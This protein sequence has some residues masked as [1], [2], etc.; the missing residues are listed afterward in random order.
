MKLP[1]APIGLEF[2]R[3]DARPIILD[4]A[5]STAV[6]DGNVYLGSTRVQGVGK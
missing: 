3:G 2:L 1:Q 6:V 5:I 4:G